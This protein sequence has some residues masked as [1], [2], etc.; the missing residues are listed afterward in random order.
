MKDNGSNNKEMA[1]VFKYGLM[2]VHMKDNG[3]MI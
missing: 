1:M 3:L 2:V